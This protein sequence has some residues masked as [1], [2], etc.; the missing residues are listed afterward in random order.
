MP[1]GMNPEEESK[2]DE[3]VLDAIDEGLQL[4]E[5]PKPVE[6][7]PEA[8]QEQDPDSPPAPE[9]ELEAAEEKEPEEKETKEELAAGEPEAETGTPVPE[10]EG[11]PAAPKSE[12][13]EE[14]KPEV[15]VKKQGDEK[16]SDEFGEL[17]ED[18]KPAT[19]E[20]FATMKTRFDEVSEELNHVSAQNEAWMN[21]I[22]RTGASPDQLGASLEYL[23][24]INTGT[25]E[26][27]ERAYETMQNELKVLAK[28]LGKEAPGYDPLE[29]YP[30]LKQKVEEGYIDKE[31]ALE[32]AGARTKANI[33]EIR[34]EP[35]TTTPEQE[36]EA[37]TQALAQLGARLRSEDPMYDKKIPV[38]KQIVEDVVTSG[39]SPD[40]WVKLVEKGYKRI[41]GSAKT[42]RKA[43]ICSEFYPARNNREN[44]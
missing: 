19:K 25:P 40:T 39:A 3:G 24:D 44:R 2:F 37:G 30:D 34:P 23:Q 8:K 11:D 12:E 6:P 5:P 38:I 7:E 42:K 15:E 1:A 28:A 13:K 27:L 4:S 35:Q 33:Q 22:Q 32:I 31:D 10:G 9:I 16:P 18:A 29:S 21:T 17:D 43:D 36:R 41:D 20:R 14:E 26:S